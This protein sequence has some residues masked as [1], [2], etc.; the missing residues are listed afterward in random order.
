ML[1]AAIYNLQ[2]EIINILQTGAD[3]CLKRNIFPLGQSLP[4]NLVFVP[5]T[6]KQPTTSSGSIQGAELL[7]NI[8][9]VK[10]IGAQ[11]KSLNPR[12][13]GSW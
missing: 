7:E 11:W 1:A 3:G 9:L 4:N 6:P 5:S 13:E 8:V 12:P 2:S 10:V